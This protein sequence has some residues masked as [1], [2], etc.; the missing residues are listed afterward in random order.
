MTRKERE[1]R[2]AELA[3]ISRFRRAVDRLEEPVT[4]AFYQV[5]I[6]SVPRTIRRAG[7]AIQVELPDEGLEIVEAPNWTVVENVLMKLRPI[8]SDSAKEKCSLPRILE[9]LPKFFAL[10]LPAFKRL[11]NAWDRTL[12][13]QTTRLLKGATFDDIIP[14]YTGTATA[15]GVLEIAV[16]SQVLTGLEAIELSLYGELQHL[17]Q[18]KD[19]KRQSIRSVPAL[20]SGYRVALICLAG[21]LLSI[22]KEARD[23]ARQALDNL[24]AKERKL[25]I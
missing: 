13:A 14:G 7:S 12:R 19:R 23:L 24:P 11:K 8:F 21:Q 17:D 22:A 9:I 20:E 10:E 25:Y 3:R 2:Q 18:D 5:K 16:D 1:L 6:K 15:E 4:E